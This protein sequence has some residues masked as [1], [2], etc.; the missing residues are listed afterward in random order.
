MIPARGQPLN[1]NIAPLIDV[2]LVILVLFL[3]TA[4]EMAPEP[5]VELPEVHA[6]SSPETDERF[7][8]IVTRAGDIFYQG[9][10]VTDRAEARLSAD[11]ELIAHGRLLVR[12]D[13]D[14]TFGA[15]ET[16]LSAAQSA[17]LD[18]IELVVDPTE[19]EAR[20]TR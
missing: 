16:L 9:D 4:P 17:G 14:A 8:A 19:R 10:N 2:M 11:D 12:G 18:H 7:T 5:R 3:I 1:V 15:V 20:S 6:P 13:E